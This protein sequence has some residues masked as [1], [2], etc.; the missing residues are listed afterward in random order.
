MHFWY[1]LHPSLPASC[2]EL[3]RELRRHMPPRLLTRDRPGLQVYLPECEFRLVSIAETRTNKSLR[4]S[5]L[6][7]HLFARSRSREVL[8]RT[9]VLT[10]QR[11]CVY[12][13][14]GVGACWHANVDSPAP[15]PE[16]LRYVWVHHDRRTEQRGEGS[17]SEIR[18]ASSFDSDHGLPGAVKLLRLWRENNLRERTMM[19][20]SRASRVCVCVCSEAC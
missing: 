7:V 2:L 4:S 5:E 10:L 20:A 17:A 19:E 13:R 15:Q 8:R 12:R 9:G 11:V 6:L 3:R 1:S 18:Q 14:V 16:G